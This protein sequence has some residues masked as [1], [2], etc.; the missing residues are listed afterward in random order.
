M[1]LSSRRTGRNHS[2]YCDYAGQR[3]G[4]ARLHYEMVCLIMAKLPNYP[5]KKAPTAAQREAEKK[6]TQ[7]WLELL[8]GHVHLAREAAKRAR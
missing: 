8:R 6:H 4:H 1:P 2:L 3:D 5:Y 7:R